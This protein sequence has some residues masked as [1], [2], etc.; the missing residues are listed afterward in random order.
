M[1]DPGLRVVK[2]IAPAGYGKTTLVNSYLN[3]DRQ[4]A[5]VDLEQVT[6]PIQVH[7]RFISA[8]APVA[9]PTLR[10]DLPEQ[11]LGLGENE[12]A[13]EA[14]TA[15]VIG[16][17]RPGLTIFV[18]NAEYL[19]DQL[20]FQGLI[21]SLIT[22]APHETR[23]VVC[24]RVNV[25][26]LGRFAG[27]DKTRILSAR[28]LRL[29]L[30]EIREIYSSLSISRET[31]ESIER[32][33]Q[34]WPIVVMMLFTLARRGR[35]RAYLTERDDV[36][37]LY[38]YLASEVLT[39]LAPAQMRILEALTAVPDAT[40]RELQLLFPGVN[41]SH[42]VQTLQSETPFVTASGTHVE[43]HPAMRE[44]IA[45]RIDVDE[46]RARLFQLVDRGDGGV[47]AAEIALLRQRPLDAARVLAESGVHGDMWTPGHAEILSE[48]PESVFR[49]YPALWGAA[50]YFRGST[51]GPAAVLKSQQLLAEIA[52]D[53]PADTRIDLM[54]TVVLLQ[55]NTG[56]LD[57]ARE[58]NS[59]F[60]T[61]PSLVG[62]P[63]AL[64]FGAFFDKLIDF[65]RGDR[66]DV[67]QYLHDF[68]DL[69]MRSTT[70]QCFRDVIVLACYYRGRGDYARDRAAVERGVGIARATN[71]PVVRSYAAKYAAMS[72]WFWGEDSVFE[73]YVS[74]LESSLAPSIAN[75]FLH[76]L[77]CARGR[78][79]AAK[80]MAE[81][82][83]VRTYAY[84]IAAGLEKS[85]VRRLKYAQAALLA[86]QRSS[87]RFCEVIARV[88]LS[89]CEPDNFAIH[90][91]R[92]EV[93]ATEMESAVL[94]EALIALRS[95]SAEGTM[96]QALQRRFSDSHPLPAS[97]PLRINLSERTVS[98]SDEKISLS[99]REFELL[100]FLAT[101]DEPVEGNVI[102]V[103]IWPRSSAE[104]AQLS[105]RVTLNR[106]RNR[107][108][109]ADTVVATNTGFTIGVPVSISPGALS[110][111]WRR[112]DFDKTILLAELDSW[113]PRYASSWAWF[114]DL[115]ER[116]AAFRSA[117]V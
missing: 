5:R 46:Y 52:D 91:A 61:H 75:S 42:A 15:K 117:A 68:A 26:R 14:L 57:D 90:I 85:R 56:Y 66:V 48:L 70:Q 104:H 81:K 96:L 97:D 95:G 101:R 11:M 67:E 74:E 64:L 59:K 108:G 35:L 112:Q 47:R 19:R 62:N 79:S 32:F 45:A 18:D 3:P 114:E 21:E 53:A 110:S 71:V 93:L 99:P 1:S 40:E 22:H 63:K 51:D 111:T 38:G 34:G 103:A 49:E 102:A 98:V 29:T 116:V 69:F 94:L 60:R 27:P 9:D 77:D 55:A 80:E 50:A 107:F 106:L 44:M 28:D 100:V 82:M 6:T 4:H 25:L 36:S 13:W 33:T 88:I 113:P 7:R 39:T 54:C 2:L 76:F 23:V 17:A 43:A 65:Y 105:L 10:H 41:V 30:E 115:E 12:S 109:R 20:P 86:A 8:F 72:A 78:A 16:S 37:D 24:S 87:Q 58:L 89:F 73:A 84:C 92:A 83:D 31:M